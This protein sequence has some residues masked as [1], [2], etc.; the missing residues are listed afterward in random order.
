MSRRPFLRTLRPGQVRSD[1]LQDIRDEIELYLELRTEELIE[2]GMSPEEAR[3]TA[4]ERFGDTA[5]I[6]GQLQRQAKRRRARRGTMMTMGGLRQDL[7][8]AARTFRRSPG[9]TLV[10]VLT[11]ALAL[12]GNTAIFSVLDAAVL[13]AMPFADA[14]ELVYVNGY[15]L[16]NGEIAIRGASFPEFRDWRERARGVTPMAAVGS[17]S[18]ALTGG[19]EAESL[20]TEIVTQDYFDV[21][22]VSVQRG[23]LFEESEYTERDAHSVV[24][25]SDGLWER[26]FGRDAETVGSSIV[27][28]DQ[29]F[30]VVGVLPAGFGGIGL[31]TDL[32]I[33]D[34]VIGVLGFGGALDARG[35]RWLSVIGRL[36]ADGEAAQ[37]ELDGVAR[38]LQAEYPRAH[39][40]R[41]AQVQSFRDAYLDS[42]QTLL[43]ILL[44]AGL[45]LLTIAAANVANLLLVRSHHRTREIVLRRALGAESVRVGGQLVTE[46]VVLATLG[47]L[48]GLAVAFAGLGV[49]G[50]MI[51]QGVLPQY[52]NVDLSPTAFG[53]SL[54]MLAVVGVTMGLVPAAASSRVDIATT[55]REGGR[56]AAG[57]LRRFRAQHAFV[58]VQVG[59]ALVLMVGAGLLTRSFR[60]QLDVE[61]GSDFQQ[62]VAARVSLPG[63]RY[64]DREARRVFA[65]E[66]ERGAEAIPGVTSV[67]VS[68]TLPFRGGSSGAYVFRQ[69][70]QDERIRFHRHSVAPGY[71]ETLGVQLQAGRFISEADGPDQPLV[72]VITEAMVRRVFP[73]ESPVGQTM[74]LQ[75]G[76]Q[77]P[78]EIIGVI[79]DLRYR[80][81]TTSLMAEGNSPDVFFPFAQIPS[82]TIEL[83]VSV[84]GAPG[85]YVGPL[86]DVVAAVDPDLPVFQAAPVAAAYAA[87]TAM[88][89]FAA[90][91]MSLLSGLAMILA[92]VGIYGV[93]SF[94]VGQRAQEIAIRRAIGATAPSVASAVVGDGLRLVA[95]GIAVGG[96]TA[97]F[98]AGVLRSFLFEV[99][100]TDPATFITVG[101]T[102]LAVAL[103]AAVIPA[104]RAT[105]R[106]P[107]LLLSS[108]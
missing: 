22:E 11:L 54:L 63:A 104:L 1:E 7:A 5:R 87:Q 96:G 17:I 107:A 70:A 36:D 84:Q 85:G 50:P 88:P 14:E 103:L 32:W 93:L 30:T 81:L 92:C 42:T 52:V 49:L 19:G 79:E 38:E 105:R 73:G 69:D 33:T 72:G 102:M 98:G 99:P 56:A 8:F 82:P 44:G 34:G 9:F 31:G 89:R 13:R 47:G 86:R 65:S 24:V 90:F 61:T 40:D 43:W 41:F 2:E 23:R 53:Y 39:E 15:H 25:I 62:V 78:F 77:T 108:E 48:A 55:L 106:D 60:A 68:S 51:P 4:E 66:L 64:P 59:L 28:N 101:G 37:A 21:L 91:L 29:T 71:F 20:S 74:Y 18:L 16:S 67:S 80:D 100:T 45:L 35:S 46:S 12:G 26:R 27:L 75:P 95:V 76:G 6:Q 94:S 97:V 58:V 10:A 3:R 83:A 57:S